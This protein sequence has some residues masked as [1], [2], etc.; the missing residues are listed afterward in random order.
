MSLPREISS[1]TRGA[2]L[3]FESRVFCNIPT[4]HAWYSAVFS[5]FAS[6][7][8]FTAFMNMIFEGRL[9]SSMIKIQHEFL[10]HSAEVN[11]Q[12][13]I[14]QTP[15][16]P[17]T[18]PHPFMKMMWCIRCECSKLHFVRIEEMLNQPL[19]HADSVIYPELYRECA[20]DFMFISLICISIHIALFFLTQMSKSEDCWL[21][22]RCRSYLQCMQKSNAI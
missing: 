12:P 9:S 13:W 18:P 6:I 21:R 15:P 5:L 4:I 17:K 2:Q 16:Q 19:L 10:A 20:P 7:F 11:A 22:R 1:I 8:H 14:K 3:S